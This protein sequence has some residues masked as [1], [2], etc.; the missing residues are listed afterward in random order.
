[1]PTRRSRRT[2]EAAAD[3]LAAHTIGSTG[4]DGVGDGV[5]GTVG[6]TAGEEFSEMNE[7]RM[8]AEIV[9]ENG[10]DGSGEGGEENG[11]G[12]GEEGD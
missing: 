11:C 3:S 1:M 8:D 10:T 12:G 4:S 9:E 7:L 5:V 6:G 2:S